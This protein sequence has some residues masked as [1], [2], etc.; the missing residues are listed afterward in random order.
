[1]FSFIKKKILATCLCIVGLSGSAFVLFS[2]YTFVSNTHKNRSKFDIPTAVIFEKIDFEKALKKASAE[3]KFVFVDFYTG[4]CGPCLDFSKN[5]MTNE[6]VGKYMNEAF[7]NLKYDAEKGEG[8]GM[9]KK[10]KVSAY[11]TLLVLDKNGNVLENLISNHSMPREKEMIEFSI[12]YRKM[13][14]AKLSVIRQ[15]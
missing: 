15:D 3:N 5:I 7:I 12:K 9:A 1:M 14:M 6:E 10:F 2:A 13:S 4:W 11:P 8:I